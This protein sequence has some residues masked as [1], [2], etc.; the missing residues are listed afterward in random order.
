MYS[1]RHRWAIMNR[2]RIDYVCIYASVFVCTTACVC[3]FESV[4]VCV[5]VCVCVCVREYV[6]RLREYVHVSV[7]EHAESVCMYSYLSVFR[8]ACI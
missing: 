5:Y 2:K 4:C 3:V 1:I 6:V 7:C 8:S